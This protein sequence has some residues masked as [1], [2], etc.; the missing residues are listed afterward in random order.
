M[1]VGGAIISF[2]QKK[3][4]PAGAGRAFIFCILEC[5]ELSGSLN[6]GGLL[7]FGALSYFEGNFLSFLEGFE[8]PHLDRREV[9][10]KIF[11]AV[12]G[13]NEAITLCIVE[14]F[15]ST[16]CHIAVPLMN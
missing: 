7:A 11:T 16:C 3:A 5:A 8:S 10:E 12:I 4:H 13:R 14:P 2:S 1:L 15:H 6:I 9:R